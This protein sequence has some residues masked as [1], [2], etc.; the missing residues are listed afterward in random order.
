MV[1]IMRVWIT[2]QGLCISLMVP[3]STEYTLLPIALGLG[4]MTVSTEGKLENLM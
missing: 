2:A 3:L 4:H 1:V